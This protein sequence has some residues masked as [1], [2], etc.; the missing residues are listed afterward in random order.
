MQPIFKSWKTTVA[1]ILQFLTF[2]FTQV[3]LL[4]DADPLTN[5]DYGLWFTSLI[6]LVGLITARDSDVSSEEA[7]VKGRETEAEHDNRI[8]GN[9]TTR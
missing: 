8:K 5:P 9:V 6:T 1:G 3:L 2:S 7:G 4:A